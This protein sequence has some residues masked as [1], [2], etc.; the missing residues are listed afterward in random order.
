VKA[1][2]AASG[3][4]LA[5]SDTESTTVAPGTVVA[6][7]QT[8]T[9]TGPTKVVVDLDGFN[10]VSSASSRLA[11]VYSTTTPSVCTVSSTGYVVAIA[12]GTCEITSSQAGNA[13]WLAATKSLTI[14]VAKTPST[15]LTEKG[16]IKKPLVLSK[17]GT[18]L[19]SGDTQLGWNRSKGTLGL[20]LSVVYVGPVKATASF[21]VGS[22]T[23]T[24][25]ASFGITKKQST[26]KMLTLTSPNLCTGK[27]EK[28]QL[29]ALKKI[30]SS[31]VVTVTVVRDMYVPTT[32]K[33]VRTKTRVLYAKL[34]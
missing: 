29:A 16:D 26:S 22:K 4:L 10:V 12:E 17:T 5:G 7:A 30:T 28:T 31:T 20:K 6:A 11:V 32:Y 24:C 27:T 18:F 25:S 23:Y 15:P 3:L 19:K 13:N 21:K 33:K 2:A 1:T 14:T 8:V 9:L 34:G